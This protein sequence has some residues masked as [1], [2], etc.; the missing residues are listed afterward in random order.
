MI[1][2]QPPNPAEEPKP[3]TVRDAG[4]AAM[5]HPPKKWDGVDEQGDQSFPASDPPG[6]YW[7]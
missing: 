7:R 1:R 6:N 5:R 2:T 3:Q 4:P